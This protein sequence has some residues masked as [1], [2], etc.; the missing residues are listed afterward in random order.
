MATLAEVAAV[1][2]VSTSA[3][4][5]YLNGKIE[6]PKVTSMRID[7]AVIELDYRP[8]LLGRRLSTGRTDVIG[9]ATPAINEIFF[10]IV[11]AAALKEANR[12]GYS[13]NVTATGD[14]DARDV[15]AL[16]A[17][18]SHF[19]DGMLVSV[20]DAQEAKELVRG[21]RGTE[22]IILLDEDIPGCSLPRI[23]LENEEGAYCATSHL[24]S[25]GHRRIAH[26]GGPRGLSSHEERRRGFL[27]AMADAGLAVDEDDISACG[28]DAWSG[29]DAAERLLAH[30][31]PPTAIFAGTDNLGLGVMWY[32]RGRGI[33]V[34][35][36]LSVVG[37]G[38]LPFAGR[39]QPALTTMRLPLVEMGQIAV[40]TLLARLKGEPVA[41]SVRLPC[42]FIRGGS[43]A[44]PG[45]WEI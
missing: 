8:N 24:I 5:R 6:L 30:P 19:V 14:R 35:T 38:D 16:S 15:A 10:G 43:V 2:G 26:V 42:T 25:A 27:R 39:L 17:L 29:M 1:A 33:G 7:A 32:C 34:P 11:A 44:P 41:Q 45:D 4:S 13:I 23:L 12:H 31:E 18:R 21:L 20:A 37:F 22:P 28:N 40:T 9:I 3:V 36:D